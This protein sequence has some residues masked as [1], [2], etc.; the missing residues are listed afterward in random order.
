MKT[1]RK[2]LAVTVEN[3]YDQ[4]ST[5]VYHVVFSFPVA[6]N[7]IEVSWKMSSHLSPICRASEEKKSDKS[8]VLGGI[9]NARE[10]F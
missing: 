9:C 6:L 3:V 1:G 4:L 2:Q 10:K 5:L 8:A 7:S